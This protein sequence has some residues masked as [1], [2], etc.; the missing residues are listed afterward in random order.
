[1][2]SKNHG[3]LLA[4]ACLMMVHCGGC[5]EPSDSGDSS[6]TESNAPPPSVPVAP[7]PPSSHGNN[8]NP[9]PPHETPASDPAPAHE[10]PGGTG[11]FSYSFSEGGCTTGKHR[12]STQ[13]DE[14]H[15]LA[16]NNFNQGCAESA[17]RKLFHRLDCDRQGSSEVDTDSGWGWSSWQSSWSSSSGS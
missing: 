10:T 14:C 7:S 16:D 15:G 1:M 8:S 13:L 17:R 6:A 5:A 2:K 11:E 9:A 4:I 3:L 12:F